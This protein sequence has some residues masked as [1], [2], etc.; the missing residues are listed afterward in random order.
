[1]KKG[2]F[3]LGMVNQHNSTFF[4]PQLSRRFQPLF[5]Y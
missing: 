3:R 2:Y 4:A 1:M 5:P